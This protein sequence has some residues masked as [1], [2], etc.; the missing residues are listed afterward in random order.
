Q[1]ERIQHIN[2][3]LLQFLRESEEKERINPQLQELLLLILR[4]LLVALLILALAGPKW[5]AQNSKRSGFLSFLP[6]GR[7]LQTH[8]VALDS[9][10][11]MGYGQGDQ[12]LWREAEKTWDSLNRSLR[13]FST[14]MIQWDRST[15]RPNQ[16][17]QLI[18]LSP[19][20]R[21]SLFAS[22]PKEAGASVLALIDS[23]N[24]SFEDAG[25]LI[26]ITDGQR[27]PWTD[28]LEENVDQRSIPRIVAAIVESG[29]AAN[30]WVEIESLSS[31]P[32]GIAGWEAV[33][34]RVKALYPETPPAGTV[35][36]FQTDGNE[37]LYSRPVS[38]PANPNQTVVIPFEFT[39]QFSDLRA[40]RRLSEEGGELNLT[41]RV[42]PLDLLPLDNEL[43]LQIPVISSFSVGVARQGGEEN[44]IL[45]VLL[46]AVNPLR[47]Q[48]DSP[49]VLIEYI[50]P[51]EMTF[52]ENLDFAL[53][54][55]DLVSPWLSVEDIQTPLDYIKNGGSVLLFTGH[56]EPSENAWSQL[57]QNLGWRWFAVE[58]EAERPDSLSIGGTGLYGQ[59]LSAWDESM[60]TRWIPTDHGR[61]Q[62]DS[63]IPLAAYRIGDQTAYLVTQ[64][65]LGKGRVWIVNASLRPEGD[66]LLSPLLPAL[67][68][69]TGKEVARRTRGDN[70][71]IPAERLESDLTRLSAEEKTFLTEHYGVQFTDINSLDNALDQVYGGVDL[72]LALLF[73][74]VLLALGESW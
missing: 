10:Y 7:S 46:S 44:P 14:R 39:P 66:V 67:I 26:L 19:L 52:G 62:D 37:T 36:I 53:L 73:F 70:L 5:T 63:A 47:G 35:S 27:F 48:P 74:C 72:R 33:S 12:S 20:E 17:N 38:Y 9:S 60:W 51:P 68:W 64:I 57:L 58:N 65:A 13:G 16:K 4:T 2:F 28:L 21:E 11:S 8:I 69:E 22:T 3:P 24:E 55:G 40:V 32:W 56:K 18:A 43:Q 54:A 71:S 25:G 15:I 29:P 59:A 61:I 42:E 1:E 49:P 34:G 31:P 23:V 45:S 41:L 6:F 50:S 30:A